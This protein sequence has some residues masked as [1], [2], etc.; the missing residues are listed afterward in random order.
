MNCL[1]RFEFESSGI[2]VLSFSD[3]FFE[4][5]LILSLICFN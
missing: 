5:L 4:I 1:E 2:I 3:E